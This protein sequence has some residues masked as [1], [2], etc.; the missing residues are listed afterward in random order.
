M[1]LSYTKIYNQWKKLNSN[2]SLTRIYIIHTCAGGI[3]ILPPG[4]FDRG[5]KL[6]IQ[7]TFELMTFWKKKTFSIFSDLLPFCLL[8]IRSPPPFLSG[9]ALWKI[10]PG[11]FERAQIWY[12]LYICIICARARETRKYCKLTVCKQMQKSHFSMFLIILPMAVSHNKP[13]L[14][15]FLCFFLPMTIHFWRGKVKSFQFSTVKLL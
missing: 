3:W 13:C 14:T 12:N 15:V 2:Q 10:S 9:K 7:L 11:N 1:I 6:T 4:I 8:S 5:K